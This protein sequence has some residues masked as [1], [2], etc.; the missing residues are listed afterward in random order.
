M[1]NDGRTARVRMRACMRSV[2]SACHL[3]AT[4]PRGSRKRL[5]ADRCTFQILRLRLVSTACLTLLLVALP[6]RAQPTAVREFSWGCDPEGGAPYVEADPKDPSKLVGFEVDVASLVAG[7]L[8]MPPRFSLR[9]LRVDQ[10]VAAPRRLRRS[11]SAASRR[12]RRGARAWPTRFPTTSSARRWMGVRRAD[13]DCFRTLA[14]LAGHHV[15]TLAATE[16]YEILLV[17]PVGS[18]T[19]RR[20]LTTT[21]C[22]RNSD[23]EARDASMQC[24]STTSWPA[25]S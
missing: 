11:A 6:A 19:S 16:A 13:K 1:V 14:D 3:R 25:A 8:H 5:H 20:C 4:P 7:E 15:G 9:R 21:T 10:P 2:L 17:A 23:L 22:T 18:T 12:A 24:C